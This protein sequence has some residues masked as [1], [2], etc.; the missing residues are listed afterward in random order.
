MCIRDR[1]IRDLCACLNELL[2]LAKAAPPAVQ[3]DLAGRLRKTQNM[4]LAYT[5]AIRKLEEH[6]GAK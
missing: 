2:D 5:A 3:G 1:Q 6:L 4:Y